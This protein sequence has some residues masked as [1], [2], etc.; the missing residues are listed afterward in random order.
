MHPRRLLQVTKQGVRTEQQPHLLQRRGR[1][2]Q[3]AGRRRVQ[4][5]LPQD[6]GRVSLVLLHRWANVRER[7]LPDLRL[8]RGQGGRRHQHLPVR[9]RPAVRRE[10]GPGVQERHLHLRSRSGRL[11]ARPIHVRL[12][13]RRRLLRPRRGPVPARHY[14]LPGGEWLL[15]LQ[16][17]V[18]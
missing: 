6:Q 17:G 2:L 1:L 14:D 16:F 12:E 11:A 10:P 5:L 9:Q 3:S 7:R 4:H 13:S 18:V 8:R 15:L